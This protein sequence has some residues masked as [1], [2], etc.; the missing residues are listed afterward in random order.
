MQQTYQY[1]I[2]ASHFQNYNNMT[3]IE[4]F[5]VTVVDNKENPGD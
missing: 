5:S 4:C 2:K 1:K 3:H